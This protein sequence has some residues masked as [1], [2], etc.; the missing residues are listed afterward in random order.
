MFHKKV[1]NHKESISRS[2]NTYLKEFC[3][4]VKILKYVEVHFAKN[5]FE[6]SKTKMNTQMMKD[7][8]EEGNLL[9][10]INMAVY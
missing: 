1:S 5:R 2:L 9:S 4:P 10:F 7:K 8:K 6:S 3:A